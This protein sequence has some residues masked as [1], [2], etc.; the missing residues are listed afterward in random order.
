MVTTRSPRELFTARY[1]YGVF[2][3]RLMSDTTGEGPWHSSLPLNRL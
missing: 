1:T 3:H 2:T